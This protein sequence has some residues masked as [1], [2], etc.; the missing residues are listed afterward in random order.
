M[1]AH[2]A[3]FPTKVWE[4]RY[5]SALVVSLSDKDITIHYY[6]CTAVAGVVVFPSYFICLA[7]VGFVVINIII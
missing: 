6:Y 5:S 4:S 7:H 1:K 3:E 2:N